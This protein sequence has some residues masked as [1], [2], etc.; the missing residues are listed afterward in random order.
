MKQKRKLLR[1]ILISAAAFMILS[2]PVSAAGN[3]EL[4][5]EQLRISGAGELYSSLPEETQRY[6]EKMG[7]FRIDRETLTGIDPGGL[8]GLVVSLIGERGVVPLGAG[9]ACLGI[10]IL[11]ALT[12]STSITIGE[13]PLSGVASMVGTLSVCTALIIPVSSVISRSIEL[14]HGAS[15][16]LL[17]YVPVMAGLMISSGHQ[18][19][20][21]SYYVSLM[22]AS[23]VITQI[24]SNIIAPLMNVFLALSLTSSLPGKLDISTFCGWLFRCAKWILTLTMSIF[25]TILTARTLVSSSLDQVSKK[26][27]RFMV[28]SFVPVVGGVLSETLSAFSGSLELLRSSAGVFIIIATA[29]LFLPVI[30]EC[31]LWQLSLSLLSGSSEILG[32]NSMKKVF[33]AV[34]SVISMLTAVLACIVAVL[35]ISTVAVLLA[36]AG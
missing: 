4:F 16:F 31:I 35:I 11:C 19:S 13:R 25:V 7:I 17:M 26:T 22:T 6:L 14:I 10:L 36:S 5:D 9:S 8:A 30:L 2:F 23:E 24:S 1:I 12:E 32:I 18:A 34:S 33:S 20:G 3:D 29:C 21:A 15:G 27:L 28:S